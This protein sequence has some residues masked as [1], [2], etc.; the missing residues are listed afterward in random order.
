MRVVVAGRKA[1]HHARFLVFAHALLEEVGLAS[2]HHNDW[3]TMNNMH[4]MAKS[5]EIGAT[6]RE[7]RGCGKRRQTAPAQ[8]MKN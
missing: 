5:A 2:A 7:P 6:R 4:A 1:I 8:K 3:S